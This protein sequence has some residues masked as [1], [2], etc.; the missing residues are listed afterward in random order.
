MSA[1]ARY[2]HAQGKSVSGYDKTPTKLTEELIA[3]GIDIHFEEDLELVGT[4]IWDP[5]SDRKSV[6]IIITPAVPKEHKELVYLQQHGF[7]IKKRSEVLGAIT[8]QTRT[9]AI[10]GTH[11]KT[12]TSSL[13]AHILKD[14]GMDIS[15]FLGGI[16]QNYNTN[17]LLGKTLETP[18]P[19]LESHRVVVEADEYDRS[20]LTLYPKVAV[21]TS[22]DADHLDI[23]G[24]KEYVEESYSMF[25][26]QVEGTLII[27][28]SIKEILQY[29]D[30]SSLT[31][32]VNEDADFSARNI[33]IEDGQYVY[34]I[35]TPSGLIKDVTLGL[36]GLHNVENS[37]AA[38]A[39]A[40]LEGVSDAAIRKALA[41]FKGVRRRFDYK[42]K[43]KELVYIDDY[44]HHPEEL[45][46]CINSVRQLYPGKKVTGI[47][48]PHLFSRT[49]DFIDGFAE[50]LSL[51]DELILMEIYPA[52]E[53]PIPGITS[54]LLLEKVKLQSKK[55]VQKADLVEE[56]KRRDIEVLITMG[57]GDIDTFVEPIKNELLKR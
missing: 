42:V 54:S 39:V 13:V 55:L 44:A 45:K 49:R 32:A 43:K 6:L 29:G 11:G 40:K 24:S 7:N 33:R 30:A 22:M 37:V 23:Y 1:L 27:K 14:A 25:A 41:S 48:Q 21:I 17:L 4:E 20:F 2:F 16:T 34:D 46:A 12:T 50:S 18:N 38:T 47:F 5:R 28:K 57:A 35:Q 15:A 52:R 8:G 56:I 31:Y 51:L 53:Q 10:A 26:Q 19:E 36:P 3:E 9:I